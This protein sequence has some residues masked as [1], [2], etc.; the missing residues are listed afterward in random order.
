MLIWAIAA[1]A[2]A[3]IVTVLLLAYRRQVKKTCRQLA[4]LKEHQTNLRF[5]S[6]WPF[7]ELDELIDGLNELIDQSREIQWVS[8]QSEDN[9]KET[10]V[11]LS[12]D[13]RT[14][15]TSLDGYFQLLSQSASEEERQ[16]YIAVIQSRITSLKDLLEELFTYTRLQN[17]RYRLDLEPVDFGKCVLDTVFSF[18][19]EFQKKG[20]EPQICFCEGRLV[21]NGNT[22]AI[23][24]A[25]QNIL[26]NAL[27]HGHNRITLE[28]QAEGEQAVFRCSN[29]VGNSDEIDIN[30]VFSRFYKA[31]SARNNTSTGLGLSIAR[32]LTDKMG[33]TISAKLEAG[34]FT[35]EM[36]FCTLEQA[37]G[38]AGEN[39]RNG[40]EQ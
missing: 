7:S 26:K 16:H 1:T 36:R 33:G 35:V 25:L 4:F 5:T 34:I 20:V 9:L 27:E 30:Q 24:R 10:I 38:P 28:L 2:A 14:P 32:G 17:D 23:R 8:R 12:H 18:Y 39:G 3:I 13:I 6:D 37:S 22:E 11:N 40:M 29:D 21:T 15:L 19:D 31:D